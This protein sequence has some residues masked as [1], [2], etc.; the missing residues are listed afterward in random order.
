M[1]SYTC[2]A[3]RIEPSRNGW[4]HGEASS[5]LQLNTN[6]KSRGPRRSKY[7]L[8]TGGAGFIGTNLAVQFLERGQ[9]VM[10]FD[11]LSRPGVERNLE[12]LTDKYGRQVDAYVADVQNDRALRYAVSAASRVY[13]F[14]AQ[15]AVTKSL[16]DPR[17][18]FDINGRGTL[19]VL[20]AIR[21]QSTP[22][23]VLFTSTNKVY[24]D[25]GGVPLMDSASRY[26]P[27]SRRMEQF[28]IDESQPLDLYSPYGCSHGSAE[29]RGRAH[30]L[31]EGD[32][33]PDRAEK[34]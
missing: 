20:E 23:P 6:G 34:T 7:I 28:G 32:A 22:P 13:H 25:L 11:N 15:V 14:A 12:W 4:N 16:D 18:D 26:Q 19:N 24:G 3:S 30:R 5:L 31:H 29:R 2:L 1:N 27:V 21:R 17:R 8:I 9:R 33:R 10:V